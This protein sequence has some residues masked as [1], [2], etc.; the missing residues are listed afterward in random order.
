MSLLI[1]GLRVLLHQEDCSR[2]GEV[3][4]SF[5]SSL[6]RERMDSQRLCSEANVRPIY[7][8]K[9]D[10]DLSKALRQLSS[11]DTLKWLR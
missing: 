7:W 3:G 8:F 6:D 11:A 2:G 5:L 1:G 9:S 4:L 10:A